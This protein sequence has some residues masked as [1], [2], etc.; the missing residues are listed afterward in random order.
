MSTQTRFVGGF[1][2]WH[3]ANNVTPLQ[4]HELHAP[5]RGRGGI[6]SAAGEACDVEA[7]SC[8]ASS[9]Q[10][11]KPAARDGPEAGVSSEALASP[12]RDG[13]GTEMR[14][15]PKSRPRRL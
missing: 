11:G 15:R 8:G 1:P 6:G 14:S 10:K 12:A 5:H 9:R 2:F 4:S 3:A 7:G 13:A